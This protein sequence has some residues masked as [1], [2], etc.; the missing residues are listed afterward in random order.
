MN[1]FDM[2]VLISQLVQL[3]LIMGVGYIA[4]KVKILNQTVNKHLSTFVLEISMP[5]MI[6]DA[7]LSLNNSIRPGTSTIVTLFVASIL[8]YVVMP[9]IAF[10]VVKIL[11]KTINIKK[12][13]QGLYMIMM[14]F[15]NVG[16][17]GF[18]ILKAA[19]GENGDLAIF[20]AAILNIFFN[21]A[22][23]TYG[24]LTVGYGTEAKVKISLKKFISPGMISSFIGIALYAFGIHYPAEG[25]GN[26][27]TEIIEGL[28]GTVG[29]LTPPLA[30]LL[31]GATLASVAVKEIFSE[32]RI[33]IFIFIRQIVLPL[34]L[35]P[36]FKIFIKDSLL[37][38]VLFIEFLMPIA[39]SVLIVANEYDLDSKFASKA[40]FISTLASIVAIPLILWLTSFY[41]I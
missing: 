17:M 15:G 20:Y 37:S 32:W 40:I 23:F 21:I 27:F 41:P 10:I 29:N 2:S 39:N 26:M 16:F 12:Y 9:I 35:F 34:L 11:A 8:F 30:M 13:R 25:H 36:I 14:V 28:F 6:I 33:Y 4:Y 38:T 19:C 22:F 31:V 5:I 7:V 18:P 3:F 1:N 24:I